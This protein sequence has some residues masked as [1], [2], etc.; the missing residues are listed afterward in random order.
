MRENSAYFPHLSFTFS[1]LLLD[2][3]SHV[4]WWRVPGESAP[5]LVLWRTDIFV[6]CFVLFC[7]FYMYFHVFLYVYVSGYRSGQSQKKL[8]HSY[9]RSQLYFYW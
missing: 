1:S 2:N 3:F 7:F 8:G 5:I 6:F 4:L 9:S